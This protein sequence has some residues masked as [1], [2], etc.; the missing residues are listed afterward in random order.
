MVRILI[1]K[2]ISVCVVMLMLISYGS[3]AYASTPEEKYSDFDILTPCSYSEEELYSAFDTPYH[4]RMLPYID[5]FLEVEELY[6][7][8]AFYLM[9]KTGFESGWFKY[10]SAENNVGGWRTSNGCYM[11]F[12]SIEDCIHHIAYN[13]SNTYKEHVGTNLKDVCSM[14][15][16]S[17][18]YY[19]YLTN[20]MVQ[21]E[22]K[23][24]KSKA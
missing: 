23:I 2:F 8:N 16:P 3:I 4:Y 5:T 11:N 6:G 19:S 1:K 13:L 14:Y 20:I 24:I 7:V 18:E 15:S 22:N 21:R 12:E 10:L 17:G 9:C